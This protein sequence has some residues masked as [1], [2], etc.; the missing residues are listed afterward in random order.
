MNF[1]Y[2]EISDLGISD[3]LSIPQQDNTHIFQIQLYDQAYNLGIKIYR[4]SHNFQINFSKFEK[5]KAKISLRKNQKALL[6][7]KSNVVPGRV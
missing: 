4:K 5:K 6:F 7:L 1:G 2:A 3:K